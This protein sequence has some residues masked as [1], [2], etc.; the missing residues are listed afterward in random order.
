MSTITPML[1]VYDGRTCIG[2]VLAR[3]R[4]GFESFDAAENSLGMFPTRDE[5]INK[6]IKQK[7]PA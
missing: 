5:A 3:G 1:S 7:A 2:F 6:C 4:R